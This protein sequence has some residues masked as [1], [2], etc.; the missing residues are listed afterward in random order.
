MI[1]S[2]VE[3]EKERFALSSVNK[4]KGG[5]VLLRADKRNVFFEEF[6][7]GVF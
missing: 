1:N 4:K 6:K 2:E 3:K 5:E 7:D